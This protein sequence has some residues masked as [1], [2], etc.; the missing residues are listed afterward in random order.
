MISLAE[1]DNHFG[2]IF[3][4]GSGQ[5]LTFANM[6]YTIV[7]KVGRGSIK[8]IEW[9]RNYSNIETGDYISDISKVKTVINWEPK[10]DIDKGI[11]VTYKYYL[12][13]KDYYW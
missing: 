4:L 2:D 9:P 6:V 3:N 12:Q 11:E 7:K 10:F 13:N 1:R 5:G 8:F